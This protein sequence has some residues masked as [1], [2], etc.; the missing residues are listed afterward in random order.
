MTD[1]IAANDLKTRGVAA[2]EDALGDSGV[3]AIS[4]RGRKRY[5]VLRADEYDRL[6]ELELAQAVAEA[7]ADYARGAFVAE[8]VADHLKRLE[9]E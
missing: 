1:D 3:A 8:S 5:V 9:A 7:R 6:R 4:V 2:I